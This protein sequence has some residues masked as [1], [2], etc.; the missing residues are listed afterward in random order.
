MVEQSETTFWALLIWCVVIASFSLGVQAKC[1]FTSRF[2]RHVE[3][4]PLKNIE[5]F[6]ELQSTGQYTP[7]NIKRIARS[8]VALR[9]HLMMVFLNRASLGRRRSPARPGPA[10]GSFSEH[11]WRQ[12]LS[13]AG[14]GRID[15]RSLRRS[16]IFYV[17]RL[18]R[19]LF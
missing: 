17:R 14:P 5:Y 9:I 18:F 12:T 19:L 3:K 11:A 8:A 1:I 16:Q 15:V 13:Q 10:P 2:W 6:E 4:S 7:K